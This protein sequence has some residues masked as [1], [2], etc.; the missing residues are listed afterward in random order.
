MISVVK[1]KKFQ[2]RLLA[3]VKP[4]LFKN[5]FERVIH[6]LIMTRLDYCNVLY[7]GLP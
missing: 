3:K 5:D 1:K 6:A 2:L 4:Y 7:E